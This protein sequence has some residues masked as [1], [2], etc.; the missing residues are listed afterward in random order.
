MEN[1]DQFTNRFQLQQ[2]IGRGQSSRLEGGGLESLGQAASEPLHGRPANGVD[3]IHSGLDKLIPE[4]TGFWGEQE[5]KKLIQQGFEVQLCLAGCTGHQIFQTCP[6]ECVTVEQHFLEALPQLRIGIL[7]QSPGEIGVR[8]AKDLELWVDAQGDAFKRDQGADDQCVIGRDAEGEFVHHTGHVVGHGLEVHAIDPSF[9]GLT[10]HGFECRNNRLEI[11]VFRQE[12]KGD[13]VFG[14][15]AE[16]AV[17]Q[18]HHRLNQSGAGLT[19]DFTHHPEIQIAEPAI[20]QGQQVARMRVGMEEA[21][22]QQLLQAAVHTD[23]HHVVGVDAQLTDR[24][25]IGELHPIDPLHRQHTTAGGLVEDCRYGDAR[26]V[27]MQLS[28]FF[29]VGRLIQVVHL[30]EHPTA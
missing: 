2:W 12:T 16:I 14:E 22:L 11:D 13:E 25:E 8:R 24:I 27:A 7:H 21:V 19:A 10:E 9:Q 18:V 26:V 23:I 20:R 15:L 6:A 30:F 1:V 5:I 17:H 3:A 29:S 4:Q 28:E